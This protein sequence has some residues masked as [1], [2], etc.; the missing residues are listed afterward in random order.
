MRII[1]IGAGMYVTGRGET[2]PGVILSSLAETSKEIPIQ[3]VVV[4][5]RK[6]ENRQVVKNTASRINPLLGSNLTVSYRTVGENPGEAIKGLFHEDS[7]DC[8]IVC[9]PDHLHHAYTCAL[10]AEKAHCLVVK[11]LTSSL[12]TAKDLVRLQKEN[13]VHGAVEFHK[14]LDET[15]LYIKK[16]LSEKRI[17]RVLYV[18]VQY[19]Q[20][21]E[22]PSSVFQN[23]AD[24]TNIFQYLG[25]H[26]VDL[27]YFLTGYLPAKAMA[28]GTF[29]VL[30]KMG[31]DTPDA[32]HAVI[33]WKDPS[34]EGNEFVSNFSTN[35]IDPNN[36]TA[37]SDQ[38][39]WLIGTG[40]RMEC[41]Q[42]DRG[43]EI[44]SQKKGIETINPYFAEYLPA[45][46]G[47]MAFSGYGYK[48]IKQFVVDVQD[49]MWG[50][51]SSDKLEENRPSFTQALVSTAVVET[52][53]RSLEK[54]SSWEN[55]DV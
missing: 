41:D 21:I 49:I 55:V 43:L 45:P 38:R 46:N 30:K 27:I 8:A 2:G 16:A 6:E 7:F 10:L 44:V 19:S 3:E 13:R 24:R 22:I 1:I 15:N 32:I 48:S 23:W 4:C 52:V 54:N 11:P 9:V 20:R 28:V 36:T 29:G 50:K 42:K 33:R 26:Y 47:T 31:I 34:G 14:R 12:E 5:A 25:V 51:I 17:G 53:N 18:N 40:G 39:I 35:W 37:L